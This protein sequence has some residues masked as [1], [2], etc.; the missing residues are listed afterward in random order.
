VHVNLPAAL[1]ELFR[2]LCHRG[3]DFGGG[4][5]VVLALGASRTSWL[6]FIEQNLGPHIEQ[7]CATFAPSAGSVSCRAM[8]Y[9]KAIGISAAELRLT[10]NP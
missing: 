2:L 8:T 4:E 3:A 7:K 5:R 9:W 1:L 6:I 10:D